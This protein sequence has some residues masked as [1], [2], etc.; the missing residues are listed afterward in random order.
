[1]TLTDK[2]QKTLNDTVKK[3]GLPI[4]TVR[5]LRKEFGN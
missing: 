3:I 5:E 4:E 1:M 2:N